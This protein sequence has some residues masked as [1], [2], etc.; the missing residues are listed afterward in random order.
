MIHV[1]SC[2]LLIADEEGRPVELDVGLLEKKLADAFRKL[3]FSEV[4]MAEDVSL[5]VEEK[6]RQHGGTLLTRSDVDKLVSAVLNASGFADV[7][8]EY[9]RNCGRDPF[10]DARKEMFPWTDKLEAVLARSLPVTD[11]QMQKLA[12]LCR[13]FMNKSGIRIASERFMTDLAVHF[14]IN[15]SLESSAE[16]SCLP[17]N[18]RISA[19][20]SEFLESGVLRVLPVSEIFPRARLSIYMAKLAEKQVNGWV[21]TLS[22]CNI[23]SE[24]A[25]VI[26]EILGAV[27]AD[28][29][30]KYPMQSDSPSHVILP[31]F[32]DFIAHEPNLWRKR[33]RDE[34][35]NTVEAVINDTV[36]E[37]ADFQLALSI[38]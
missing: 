8:G 32:L 13:D 31:D 3:G 9:S 20:A 27:R 34:I 11:L 36:L 22:V 28:L 17:W 7:A 26:L 12:G 19:K 5:T 16:I 14:L 23:F 37:K 15:G 6:I 29:A 33:T 35:R 30:C 25:P 18:Q 24:L 10:E 21:S 2:R 4:W 38:R 1:A